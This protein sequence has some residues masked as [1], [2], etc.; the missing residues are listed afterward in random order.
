M[1]AGDSTSE[2]AKVPSSCYLTLPLVS[3]NS[4]TVPA[5]LPLV[6]TWAC[7]IFDLEVVEGSPLLSRICALTLS[8]AVISLISINLNVNVNQVI[9]T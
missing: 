3:D 8:R 5:M 2:F 1:A 9:G 7:L 4:L 6:M